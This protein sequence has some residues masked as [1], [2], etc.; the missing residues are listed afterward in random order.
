MTGNPRC[1]F[2]DPEFLAL[3]PPSL[4]AP[5]QWPTCD[6]SNPDSLP[7]VAGNATDMI[8]QLTSWIAGDPD[9][10]AFLQGA[11]DP[12][13]MHV[14]P[15]YERPSYPG[16]PT[17]L[18]TPQDSTGII[19]S[20]KKSTFQKRFEWNPVINGLDSS[21]R[22]L[23]Q[24]TSSCQEWL[25]DANGI[26]EGCPA[27]FPGQRVLIGI[28]DSGDAQSYSLPEAQL[29]NPAGSFVTPTIGT[30][31]A[32]VNDMSL[33]AAT[34]TQ[35]L[36]Y[37]VPDTAYS[38]DPNAYP[39]AMVQYAMLPTAGLAP[40]KATAVSTFFQ[41]VTDPGG[42]QLYGRAPGQLGPGF[43]DLTQNQLG[44]AQDALQHVSVQDGTL[45]GNQQPPAPSP[46]PSPTGS[47]SPT[48]QAAALNSAAGGSAADDS[49]AANSGSGSGQSASGGTSGAGGTGGDTAANPPAPNATPAPSG[50][51]A[52]SAAGSAVAAAP[53][54]VPVAA[55]TPSPDRAG[56]ARLL[57]PVVLI[58]GAVL[59]VGGPAA[60]VFSGTAAGARLVTR[61]RRGPGG[62]AR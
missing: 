24:N 43:A 35:S 23:L 41:Q 3:N 45:P 8:Q 61:L 9:A 14:D 44:S 59:L 21:V 60:L 7:V 37:G 58:I 22:M 42:G 27:L 54:L 19:R 47:P 25:A 50:S 20:D 10:A 26:N 1:I 28:I 12:W 62:G 57:L 49:S 51:P 32:A 39:L 38:R 16:Y 11:P 5:A 36:P 2:E 34:N 46:T 15:Y 53:G 55:G 56:L 6:D 13:G 48:A 4:I 30:V 29:V 52:P 40:V 18:L 17:N 31:Q 33:S